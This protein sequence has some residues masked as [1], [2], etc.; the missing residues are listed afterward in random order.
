MAMIVFKA[1]D[2]AMLLPCDGYAMSAIMN[3]VMEMSWL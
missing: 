1:M 3:I 2:I